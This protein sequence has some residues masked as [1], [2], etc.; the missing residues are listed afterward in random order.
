[1]HTL[2]HQ[3]VPLTQFWIQPNPFTKS[4]SATPKKFDGICLSHAVLVD[5]VAT[6]RLNSKQLAPHTVIKI[7]QNPFKKSPSATPKKGLVDQV[8]T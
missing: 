8:P 3:G 2:N 6:S 4:C 5:Q 1:M 7:S